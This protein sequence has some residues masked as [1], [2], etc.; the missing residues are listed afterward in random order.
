M[1]LFIYTNYVSLEGLSDHET[2]TRTYP[3]HW[4]G[5]PS[6]CAVAG[7]R[8]PGTYIAARSLRTAAP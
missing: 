5:A 1:L 4:R 8:D 7:R 6:S 2:R 3:V